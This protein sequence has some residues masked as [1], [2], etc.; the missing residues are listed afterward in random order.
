VLRVGGFAGPLPGK[1]APVAVIEV[2]EADDGRVVPTEVGDE[3]VVRLPERGSTGYRWDLEVAGD[4]ALVLERSDAEA[5]AMP[6]APGERRLVFRVSDASM[7][8]LVLERRR[9]P[10]A[11]DRRFRLVVDAQK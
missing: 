5:G 3:V 4:P 10:G 1:G 2:T 9:A 7:S 6:G 8:E 11:A